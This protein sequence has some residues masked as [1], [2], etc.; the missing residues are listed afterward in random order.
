ME[1][2][3][4]H[5]VNARGAGVA[6]KEPRARVLRRRVGGSCRHRILP[7]IQ[8][9]RASGVD[10]Q[11]RGWIEGARML[12]N[13]REDAWVGYGCRGMLNV[14]G[15]RGLRE[16][17]EV[18]D[19]W[20]RAASGPLVTSWGLKGHAIDRVLESIG[21]GRRHRIRLRSRPMA[22]GGDGRGHG[23]RAGV[24]QV[25]VLERLEKGQLGELAAEYARIA[26]EMVEED[27]RRLPILREVTALVETAGSRRVH[28]EIGWAVELHGQTGWVHAGVFALAIR[29]RDVFDV[30]E[31]ELD[32]VAGRLVVDIVGQAGLLTE[33]IEGD[34]IHCVLAHASPCTNAEGSA[35]K[36]LDD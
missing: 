17:G 24:Q 33:G 31:R 16:E 19:G 5:R 11:V 20:D 30:G 25:P 2:S 18:G 15:R 13:G 7:V 10:P 36:V 22:D 32:L 3:R 6:G 34:E 12:G 1:R 23:N 9:V 4:R 21:S 26:A 14:K 27:L 8:A 29:K 35:L 28:E